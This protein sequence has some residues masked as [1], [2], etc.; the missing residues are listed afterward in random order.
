VFLDTVDTV[1]AF[2]ET[3]AGMVQL[4]EGLRSAYPD[5]LLVQNRG[6]TILDRVVN[7]ID[8]VMFE[9]LSTSY[10]FDKQE[11][12]YADD[13]YT[14]EQLA[15]LHQETGLPILALDY[16]P[17]DNPAMAY[18]AV[19]TA[20]QYGFIPAVSVINLDD[21][22]D[23]GIDKGGPEDVRVQSIDV[24]SDG[25][26]TVIITV[27]ENIGLT[28]AQ[29][30]SV[31]LSVDGHEIATNTYDDLGIGQQVEW[32]VPWASAAE[33][34]SIR[35]TAFSLKDRKAGN[36][37][38]N[39]SY[40]A[41]TVAVEPLLPP[42]Q[43]RRRPPENGP[44][45][46]ATALTSLPTIDGDLSDWAG[47]PCTDVN[48]PG[49]I[50]FGD[51]A[52]WTGPDDLSGSVCYAW[53]S[54]NL[55]VALSI[56][57]DVIVQKHTGTNI[58]RGDHVE[59]W[60]DTQ[61]QL[62]FDSDSANQDDFQLGFSPGD[63]DKVPP[64]IFIWTPPTLID[65]YK[66]VQY[67]VK[68][69]AKGYSAELQIPALVLTGLRLAQDHAIGATFDPSDTDTPGSS[70]QE[71][72]LSTAPKT[73]W[74]VPTLWNNLIFQGEPTVTALEF[75]GTPTTLT[76]TQEKDTVQVEVKTGLFTTITID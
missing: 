3:T 7:D 28:P 25:T 18:R 46:V 31:S 59:L 58:W 74:G 68:R 32:R 71:L 38:A 2:P 67:A 9:D 24:Q 11:Y 8:A 29:R 4:I 41:E 44:D 65:S 15:A 23:Y 20:Q 13:S 35:V 69:A 40:K 34:A 36:N 33:T 1:D 72:M 63:F 48:Q 49:Q 5:A 22:P 21:I 12:I 37:T 30:V 45:L 73:Q 6:F 26:N 76:P 55:Y 66:T 56:A 19:Q 61:L 43:Q 50:S 47:I 70:E 60:F 14:A 10:D 75:L 27:V 62:D 57:D 64:D 52:G 51:P 16:A 54:E 39:L 53:D 17:P 42:N